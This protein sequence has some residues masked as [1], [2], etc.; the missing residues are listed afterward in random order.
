M[1]RPL[2]PCGYPPLIDR[3]RVLRFR[4]PTAQGGVS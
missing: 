3:K 4:P 2:R 1:P